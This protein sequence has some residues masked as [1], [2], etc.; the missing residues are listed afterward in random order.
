LLILD[1]YRPGGPAVAGAAGAHQL[2]DEHEVF[3]P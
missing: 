1:Q 2:G 3:I